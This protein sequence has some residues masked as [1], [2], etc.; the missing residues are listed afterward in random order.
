MMT[1]EEVD[2]SSWTLQERMMAGRPMA[3]VDY[4]TELDTDGTRA[5]TITARLVGMDPLDEKV[6]LLADVLADVVG[7]HNLVSVSATDVE[8]TVRR[9]SRSRSWH[10]KD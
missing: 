9:R 3:I 5:E 10:V 4:H 2:V 8:V 6:K 1:V 7:E